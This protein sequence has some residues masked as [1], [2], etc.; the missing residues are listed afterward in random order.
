MLCEN[1]NE[2]K[3]H[4][5]IYLGDLILKKNELINKMNAFNEN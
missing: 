2:H 5:N 3:N 1:E 4:N